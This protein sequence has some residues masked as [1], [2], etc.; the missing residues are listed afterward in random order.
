LGIQANFDLVFK[1]SFNILFFIKKNI[2]SVLGTPDC[3]SPDFSPQG[4]NPGKIIIIII[5]I[6][7]KFFLS[8]KISIY[9]AKIVIIVRSQIPPPP[10]EPSAVP[11]LTISYRE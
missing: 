8:E 9:L 4:R 1:K 3:S 6:I 2:F 7:I 11:L 5:M 10:L